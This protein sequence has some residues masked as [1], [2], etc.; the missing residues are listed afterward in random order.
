MRSSRDC[1]KRM[2][3]QHDLL[4]VLPPGVP[5]LIQAL[6]DDEIDFQELELIIGRF[7]SIVA[8]LLSLANSSWVAPQVPVTSLKWACSL[9]GQNLVRSVSIALSVSSPFDPRRCPSFDSERFWCTALLAADGA[10][11]LASCTESDNIFDSRALHT[12]GLLH[13][14]GLL[15]LADNK[16]KET[17]RVFALVTADDQKN[18]RECLQDIVGMDYC[19]VGGCLGRAW[20]LP[21]VFVTTMENQGNPDYTGKSWWESTV[22]GV[23]AN[24]V[25][26][27]FDE[28]DSQPEDSFRL[29]RLN[30][31]PVHRDEV[32]VK[33]IAKF[34]DTLEMAR[35]LFS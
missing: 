24:M 10:V 22:V 28:L 31:K 8:R 12:A 26:A 3:S 30:I 1:H 14:L 25:S 13:N 18:V 15:W 11:L 33:L 35:V 34:K 4:P 17:T 19:E 2:I 27:L 5:Y 20:S 23:S 32:Y 7:P 6:A 16:P 29:D 9:L 21:D